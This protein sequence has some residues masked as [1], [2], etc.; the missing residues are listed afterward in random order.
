MIVSSLSVC[1]TK[2]IATDRRQETSLLFDPNRRRLDLRSRHRSRILSAATLQSADRAD[3]HVVIAHHL[4][5]QPDARQTASLQHVSLGFRHL[6]R[7]AFHEFYSAGRATS[8]PT[9][10]MQLVDSSIL[11]QS[12]HQSLAGRNIESPDAFHS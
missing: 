6:R 3:Y 11:L 12:E 10:G 4:A 5:T 9:A 1:R 2:K 7:F 8:M